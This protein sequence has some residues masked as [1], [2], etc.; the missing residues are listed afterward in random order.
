MIY[1]SGPGYKGITFWHESLV[2]QRIDVIGG[3]EATLRIFEIQFN[4]FH[5]GRAFYHEY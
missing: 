1:K 2:L 5:F 4:S 3:T